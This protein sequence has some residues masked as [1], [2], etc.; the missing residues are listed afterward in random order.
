MEGRPAI[1]VVVGED[2]PIVRA[3]IVSVLEEAGFVVVGVA[4]DAEELLALTEAL[5]PDVV[6]TD[7]QMPRP[8]P[9]MV[10]KRPKPSDQRGRGSALS[11]S[12]NFLKLTTP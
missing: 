7:I 9:T 10:L 5:Q 1:R 2:H 6:I 12:L 3:G 11:S 4:K 8:R